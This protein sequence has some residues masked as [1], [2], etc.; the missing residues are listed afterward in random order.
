[1]YS[2]CLIVPTQIAYIKW[3][4]NKMSTR[5]AEVVIARLKEVFSVASDSALCEQIG[6]SPQTLSSWK[7]RNKIPYAN[8]VEIS[9]QKGVSLDWL[10]TGRGNKLLTAVTEVGN[11]DGFS[12]ADIALMELLNQ[13]D[14]EVRRDLLRG[15][16]EKQRMR[17]LEKKVAEL[18]SEL[19]V[20]KNAG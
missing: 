9:K 20:K 2:M 6:V 16:E 17:E 11:D 4:I 18:S 8:C 10:L 14:P 5:E 13:L 15:A 1:M 12:R 3:V 19:H 7:A